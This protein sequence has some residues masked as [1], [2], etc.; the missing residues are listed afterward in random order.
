MNSPVNAEVVGR[1]GRL[2]LNRPD[3]INAIDLEMMHAL[4]ET[5]DAWATDPAV[6][7]I[8]LE[9]LG[10]YGFCAGG[11]F[12]E[13]LT[14]A[15][16]GM[17]I[18]TVF[19]R[20]EYRLI[21][22]LAE[23]PKPIVSIMH[24]MTMGGGI[25]LAGHVGLRVVSDRVKLG[26]PETGYGFVPDGG[27]TW[28]LARTPGEIGTYLALN[29][30]DM[31]AA[32]AVALGFADAVV[33]AARIGELTAALADAVDTAAPEEKVR[34]FAVS[35][36]ESA[37]MARRDWIDACYSADTVQEI[38]ERLWVFSSG[39]EV[40]G[41]RASESMDPD[42]AAHATEAAD[43]LLGLSPTALVATLR[44][45]RA[46]RDGETLREALERE[47]RLARWFTTQPDMFTGVQALVAQ[48]TETLHQAVV[49]DW[50]P[51]DL[52]AVDVTDIVAAM[53][54]PLRHSVFPRG[55][56]IP[57]DEQAAAAAAG[58]GARRA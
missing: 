55:L 58:R 13:I 15:A 18:G 49:P 32:D 19:F 45:V 52:S 23:H 31:A 38:L 16:E 26:Q 50:K 8:L 9:G 34:R 41:L 30:A 5:L 33:P 24:G 37:V 25:S 28:R 39:R 51:A 4:T 53:E 11:D 12:R 27:A 7:A 36:G 40:G 48:N 21:A 29:S 35:P 22:K 57:E 54:T 1:L 3:S 42:A 6:S 2:G 46:A 17:T 10:D 44:S 14:R 43:T 20:D 47:L 56:G